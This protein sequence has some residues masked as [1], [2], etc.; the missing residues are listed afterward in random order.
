MSRRRRLALAGLAI[1]LGGSGSLHLAVPKLYR[2]IVP[3]PLARWRSVVV[4]MSGLAEIGCA[5]LLL[6]PRTR[7]VG[8]YATALMFVAVFPANVQMAVDGGYPDAGFPANNA[9]V[10]WLRLPLQ[11][12]LIWWALSFRHRPKAPAPCA[13]TRF[14]RRCGTTRA[15]ATPS[16]A[17]VR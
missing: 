13:S 8:A 14:L 16:S 7:R 2:R 17:L 12:P 4:T 6:V 1:L 5:L 15:P 3:A 9:A 10:A 11:V